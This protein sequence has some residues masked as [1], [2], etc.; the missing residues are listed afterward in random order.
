MKKQTINKTTTELINQA[1]AI[2]VGK[3]N[4]PAPIIA[5][6]ST[7]PPTNMEGSFLAAK[8]FMV[9]TLRIRI[10]FPH[11]TGTIRAT[12]YLIGFNLAVK[13]L[14]T[15]GSYSKSSPFKVANLSFNPIRASAM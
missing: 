7:K 10:R 4:I 6:P 5:P 3:L 12:Y 1:P 11:C 9:F 14:N 2:I 8:L 13:C 15:G